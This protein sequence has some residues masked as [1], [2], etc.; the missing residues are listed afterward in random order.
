MEKELPKAA[1]LLPKYLGLKA[2]GYGCT[3]AATII[4]EEKVKAIIEKV[5]P[6]IPSTNPL[7]FASII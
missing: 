1:K 4:G 3:S 7:T 2:I 5:H 6:N